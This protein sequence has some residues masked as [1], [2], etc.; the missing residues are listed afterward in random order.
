M[1]KARLFLAIALIAAACG[2]EG[3]APEEAPETLDDYF[4]AQGFGSQ[5]EQ[6]RLIEEATV[7]CMA[8]EG[9]EYEPATLGAFTFDDDELPSDPDEFRRQF[10]Y[11]AAPILLAAP[12]IAEPD[13]DD[14]NAAYYEG[15]SPEEQAAYDQALYG[16]EVDPD[17]VGQGFFPTE[18]CLIESTQ[19]V[20]GDFQVL[21]DLQ[22]RLEDL[23]ASFDA[24][25]RIIE[26]TAEWSSC[27]SEAGY[28]Y[29][30][31]TQPEQEFTQAAQLELFSALTES[32][33]A[34]DP[35]GRGGG[36]GDLDTSGLEALATREL[37]VANADQD[38]RDLHVTEVER[39]VREELEPQFIEE[40]R[41]L[42]DQVANRNDN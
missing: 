26:V 18:G 9:F 39:E 36:F 30:T 8:Q 19:A 25:P 29:S 34:L 13:Q 37:E 11:G 22:S 1:Q 7:A 3:A 6:T 5:E 33:E 15:L 20:V 16:P 10:G 31:L 21:V 35:F 12:F 27:M 40:N 14:P 28:E 4:G 17:E 24:D 32:G 38:C 23:R 42:L 2:G 41:A